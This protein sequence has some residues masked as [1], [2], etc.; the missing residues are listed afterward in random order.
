LR[1]FTDDISW[2]PNAYDMTSSE[3]AETQDVGKDSKDRR[4]S[5]NNESRGEEPPPQ[6]LEELGAL[7]VRHAMDPGLFFC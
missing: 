1:Q 4:A 6:T 7:F 5:G 3:E 2:D